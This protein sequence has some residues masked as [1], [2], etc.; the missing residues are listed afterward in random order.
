MSAVA[1]RLVGLVVGLLVS[2]LVGGGGEGLMAALDFNAAPLEDWLGPFRSQGAALVAGEREPVEGFLYPASAAVLFMPLGLLGPDAAAALG[3]LLQACS[4]ALV[5]ALAPTLGGLAWSRRWDLPFGLAVGL[6]VPLLHSLH[7]GQMGAP[8]AALVLLWLLGASRPG[9]PG[10]LADVALALAVALKGYPLLA[11]APLIAAGWS[12]RRF[13]LAAAALGL[14]LPAL[15]LGADLLPF[16]HAVVSR[17]VT[18]SMEGGA[19]WGSANRQSLAA[20]LGRAAGSPGPPLVLTASSLLAFAALAWFAVR[21]A[22]AGV[23]RHDAGGGSGNSTSR[24]AA[25]AARGEVLGRGTSETPTGGSAAD[26]SRRRAAGAG[27]LLLAGLVLLPGPAWPHHLAAL[28]L[29]WAA[30][31]PREGAARACVVASA[32]VASAPLLLALGGWER[33]YALGLP[34]LAN[35]LAGL[36]LALGLRDSS[37]RP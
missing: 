33:A 20:A 11:A 5:A 17:L 35:L 26:E 36:A 10:A 19:W 24:V 25:R 31:L 4:I 22:R 14:V 16:T 3:W 18:L 29:L 6:C 21:A 30:A 8:L 2:V 37:P 9:A 12:P 15:V 27:L 13:L 1:M 7:W 32:I 34:L 28:P 23:S